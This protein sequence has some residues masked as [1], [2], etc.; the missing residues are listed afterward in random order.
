MTSGSIYNLR[1]HNTIGYFALSGEYNSLL[2]EKSDREGFVEDAAYRGFMAIATACRKFANDALEE[3]RRASDEF[4]RQTIRGASNNDAPKTPEKSLDVVEQSVQFAANAQQSTNELLGA[5]EQGIKVVDTPGTRIAGVDGKKALGVLKEALAKAKGIQRSLEIGRYASSA[6]SL[7]RQELTDNKERILALYESAAVGLSARGLAH[8]L[9]THL[10]EIRKRL[11]NIEALYKAG[12]SDDPAFSANVRSI[13]I[14]CSSISSAAALIDPL[15]PRT[16]SIREKIELHSFIEEYV[17][18][19]KSS[20]DR[21]DIA[22]ELVPAGG[23]VHVK[24]NRGRLLQVLDNLVRNS[25]YWLRRGHAVMGIKRPKKISAE[26]LPDGFSISDSGPGVDPG[27]EES[28]FEIFVTAK[29]DADPGQGLGLFIVSQ[30]LEAEGCAIHLG[31]ERNQ[32][33]R[34]ATFVVNLGPALQ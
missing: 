25:A 24:F 2:V 21:E 26:V 18:N 29:P 32:E 12:K 20:L 13:K 31:P 8:E 3:A 5:L 14:S 9:R 23:P 34:Y 1:Y 17:E 15:L 4:Y 28:L 10:T 11:A 16:R 30:L 33:G 6:V 19:R 27:Y 22:F 7:L